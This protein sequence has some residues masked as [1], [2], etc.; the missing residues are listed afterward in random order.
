MKEKKSELSLVTI[1]LDGASF[2]LL[3]KYLEELD[4]LRL[5]KKQGVWGDMTSCLPPVSAPNWKCFSTGKNPGKLGIYWWENIDMEKNNIYIP[6]FRTDQKEI[7]DYLNE[8]EKKTAV[9]NMPLSYPPKKVEGYF[10]S[11]GPN[12]EE[13]NYTYPPELEGQLKDSGYKIRPETPINGK[14]DAKEN[15]SEIN[16]MIKN[17]FSLARKFIREK[18]VNYVHLTIFYINVLQHFL[19]GDNLLKKAWKTIDKELGKTLKIIKKK[20]SNLI[21]FSDHGSNKIKEVFNINSW[22]KK[23]G[24]L[25]TKKMRFSKALHKLGLARERF[26]DLAISLKIKGLLKRFVPQSFISSIP[27][28]EG[29]VK[30]E[31]KNKVINWD[32]STAVASGQGPL[33][34]NSENCSNKDKKDLVNKLKSLKSPKTG[35]EILEKIYSKEEIYSGENIDHAPDLVLDQ[36]KNIHIFGDIGK[37]QIFESPSKWSAENKRTGL[38]Y[39]YGPS[40]ENG[41]EV[42]NIRI[43]DIAPT[44]LHLFGLAIPKDL[45]G[46]VR[47]EIFKKGSF[48]EKTSI[49]HSGFDK[50]KSIKRKIKNL[51]KSKKI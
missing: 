33:Y 18:D 2:E 48:A 8:D 26:I 43:L 46:N 41:K 24:L 22:L 17:K 5:L 47:K 39:A 49:T 27:G 4:T 25:V 38:F 32:K 28:K 31:G 23:E 40:F 3:D 44:I 37:K 1:G 42:K 34:L 36:A 20:K 19:W 10:I 14:H 15:F 11:G 16:D 45:D 29:C 6:D 7:W 9:I 12:A 35:R 13:N 50:R 30:R 21:I 51:K